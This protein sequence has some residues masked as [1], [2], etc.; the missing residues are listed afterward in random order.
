MDTNLRA[1]QEF[2]RATELARKNVEA[3]GVVR[4]AEARAEARKIGAQAEA[5]AKAQAQ[6]LLIQTEA[7]ANAS[8]QRMMAE[9]DRYKQQQ[10][11]P[12]HECCGALIPGM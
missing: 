3:E 7:E 9:A 1:V 11:R 12:A 6:R 2:L 4:E 5:E 10:A 8:A